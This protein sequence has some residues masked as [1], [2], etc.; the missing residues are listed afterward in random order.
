MLLAPRVSDYP[1]PLADAYF[2]DFEAGYAA[3]DH[4]GLVELGLRTWA[5]GDSS[6]ETR[7]MLHD[8]VTSMFR[9][10]DMCR[11]DPSIFDR[12]VEVDTPTTLVVGGQDHHSVI[13]CSTAIAERIPDCHL[14]VPA[15]VD[16]LVPMRIPD[17]IAVAVSGQDR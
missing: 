13:G 17:A 7:S 2:T 8:A 6:T 9:C 15:R 5:P 4:A 14:S 11:P 1:W 16:H 12:L 3:G 10:G